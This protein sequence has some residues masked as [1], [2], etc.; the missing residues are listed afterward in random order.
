MAR[1]LGQDH[2]L[3]TWVAC[4]SHSRASWW[5]PPL[6]PVSAGRLHP[7]PTCPGP[8][9]TTWFPL[10]LPALPGPPSS[11]ALRGP[12][13]GVA[14][15]GE[16]GSLSRRGPRSPQGQQHPHNQDLPRSEGSEG[17]LRWRSVGPGDGT[18]SATA[19]PGTGRPEIL[20]GTAGGAAL[21]L[22]LL[23]D[24]GELGGVSSA[25]GKC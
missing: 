22:F 2:A 21:L 18:G 15:A 11:P 12:G 3:P 7:S 8:K 10:P 16:A 23:E 24:H 19:F 6:S 17:H 25:W 14:V 1:S 20:P 5:S 13:R 9:T 4:F